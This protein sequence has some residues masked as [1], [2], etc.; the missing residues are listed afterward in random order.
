MVREIGGTLCTIFE[1]LAVWNVFDTLIR[2][3]AQSDSPGYAIHDQ[4]S[5][6]NALSSLF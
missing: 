1:D 6:P 3:Y 5:R 2:Q 4:L